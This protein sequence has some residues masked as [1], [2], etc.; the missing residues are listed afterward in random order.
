MSMNVQPFV[1]NIYFPCRIVRLICK[2][3]EHYTHIIVN[4]NIV[5]ITANHCWLYLRMLVHLFISIRSICNEPMYYN[6]I[7]ISSRRFVPQSGAVRSDDVGYYE[8][9]QSLSWATHSHN[10]G[11]RAARLLQWFFFRSGHFLYSLH[12]GTTRS[13]CFE[14]TAFKY[15]EAKKQKSDELISTRSETNFFTSVFIRPRQNLRFLFYLYF[16]EEFG[17]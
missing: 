10:P 1:R 3:Q 2:F 14:S 9:M 4:V 15:Q 12:Y 17:P 11:K 16:S 8:S 13:L 5:S 6:Y 7:I